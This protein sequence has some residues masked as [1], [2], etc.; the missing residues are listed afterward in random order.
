MCLLQPPAYIH[1]FG[2][3]I[4]IEFYNRFVDN[5]LRESIAA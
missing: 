5:R 1:Y 3:E 2:G 4:S